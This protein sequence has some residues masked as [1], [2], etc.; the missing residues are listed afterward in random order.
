MCVGT[1][2]TV[3]TI[4]RIQLI[5]CICLFLIKMTRIKTDKSE[6]NTSFHFPHRLWD[7]DSLFDEK[8]NSPDSS[9]DVS[10]YLF[11]FLALSQSPH[12]RDKRGRKRRVPIMRE[13][14]KSNRVGH[15]CCRPSAVKVGAGSGP[16]GCERQATVGISWSRSVIAAAGLPPPNP[17][18]TWTTWAI[19]L[20]NPSQL[21][22]LSSFVLL[23]PALFK[24]SHL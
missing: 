2:N 5:A 17:R 19:C 12:A 7:K 9:G 23:M 21:L 3:S 24:E 6:K 11:V 14:S 8:S 10:V 16:R 18:Y 1:I 4:D 13:K 22:A 15:Q 20:W